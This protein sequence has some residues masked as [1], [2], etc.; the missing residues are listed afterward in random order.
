MVLQA[1]EKIPENKDYFRKKIYKDLWKEER[2][3]GAMKKKSLSPYPEYP[4]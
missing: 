3:G 4:V 1:F 2:K